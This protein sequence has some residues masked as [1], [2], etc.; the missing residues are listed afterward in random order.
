MIPCARTRAKSKPRNEIEMEMEMNAEGER[1]H[2]GTHIQT[3][4]SYTHI[5]LTSFREIRFVSHALI[6]TQRWGDK[7][8]NVG[9]CRKL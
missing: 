9:I 7:R 3:H 1:S 5:G 8:G 4:T 2:M 6:A